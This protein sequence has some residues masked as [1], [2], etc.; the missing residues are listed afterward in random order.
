MRRQESLRGKEEVT[1]LQDAA[2]QPALSSL[3]LKG[4]P[5]ARLV[6]M[7]RA[8][9]E[10]LECY[11]VLRKADLNIVGEVLRGQG[12][13]REYDHYPKDDVHDAETH[14]QYYYHAHRGLSGE[15]GHF[16]TYL[17]AAAMPPHVAPADLPHDEPWPE[18]KEAIAHLIGISM[19]VYG[20]PIGLFA[21]NRWVAGDTWYR[22]G[23]VIQMLPRFRV[24]HAWPSWPV[25][26]WMSAMLVLFA[27]HVEQLL[28]A[29]DRTLEAWRERKPGS[30]V[31]EWRELEILAQMPISVEETVQE[32]RR[33]LS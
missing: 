8:G 1:L 10:I 16:H 18:G 24:D 32:L 28:Q 29:R 25:N 7:L 14:A 6:S 9:E 19:D 22:A 23:D 17:R 3:A 30:D 26:R 21:P 4:L 15:H 31:L 33:L 2:G 11:R 27:P 20:Y 5:R 12:A 13:F